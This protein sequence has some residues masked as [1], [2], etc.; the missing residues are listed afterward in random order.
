MK[1]AAF[2]TILAASL[3][4]STTAYAQDAAIVPAQVA[5]I[6]PTSAIVAP[7]SVGDASA[8]ATKASTTALANQAKGGKKGGRGSVLEAIGFGLL[9]IMAIT[10][11][12]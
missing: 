2:S 6:S 11:S 12:I 8:N 7:S 1:I 10:V 5:P 3:L 4:A 9:S